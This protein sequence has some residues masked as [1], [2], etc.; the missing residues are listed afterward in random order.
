MLRSAP[1]WP[2]RASV[3]RSWCPVRPNQI[4]L[5]VSLV[6][7]CGDSPSA[8]PSDSKDPH[9][10]TGGDGDDTSGDGDGDSTAGG[11]DGDSHMDGGPGGGDGD[12]DGGSTEEHDASQPEPTKDGGTPLTADE[13]LAKALYAKFTSCGLVTGV[14]ATR[15]YN[16]GTAEDESD[17]CGANCM[18]KAT[19]ADLKATFCSRQY[20][21]FAECW[22]NCT[23][24]PADGFQCGDSTHKVIPYSSVCDND[25]STTLDCP[26][27]KDED[28]A[29]CASR[30]VF[31]CKDGDKV[32]QSFVCD[33]RRETGSVSKMGCKDGSDENCC[34]LF[35]GQDNGCK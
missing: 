34:A 31:T 3:W 21:D 11:G 32:P 35:C 26:N 19:C 17:R 15:P 4:L 13:K 18:I 5:V 33:G 23:S 27:K 1:L 29:L 24:E 28:P 25:S 10:Q 9:S 2:L 16:V 14:S 6:A 20:N 8:T 22:G 7:A 30:G 12:G